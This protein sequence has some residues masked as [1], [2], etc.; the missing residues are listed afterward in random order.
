V[1]SRSITG[2]V[3][4]VVIGFLFLLNNLGRNIP[5]WSLAWDYWPVL[6]IVI[7]VIGLVEALYHA[8]RGVPN[9][10][11]MAGVGIFWIVMLVAFFSW[12][13][14][15]GNIHFG[16][17]S[18]GGINILGTDYEYD[19]NATGAS[20][21]V[22][23]V[24]LDNLHGNLSLKGQEAG[25]DVKVSGKKSVRAFSR[26]DAEQADRE[27]PIRIERQGDLLIIHADEPKSSH[28]LSVS[29]D[30]DITIPKGIDVE[31]RGRAGDLTIDDI[32]GDVDIT[33][34][35]GDIRLS[36]IAKDVKV[37][38]TRGGLIRAVD[39]KGKVDLEGPRGGD[40][41]LENV[42]GA[43]TINGEYS[44]TLE[45]HG[46]AKPL[47]FQSQK[48][49]FRLEA[50]PG[51]ITL[52]LGD[53][54]MSNVTG[55]VRFQT[56]SRD[57]EATDVTVGLEIAVQRGDV[58]ITQTKIPLPKLDIHSHNGD[59]TLA[60]PE[61]AGFELDGTTKHGDVSNDFGDPLKS[62]QDG[63]AA[64]IRGKQGTG[65]QI[66]IGTDRGTVTVKKS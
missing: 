37:E 24:V 58:E 11:R 22:S 43:V 44:G 63:R 62:E 26:N 36:N 56:S 50:V 9:P 49:D 40:I 46:L 2:P 32:G 1:R 21:G 48:T 7:G 65:P 34:G 12:A 61:K 28:M 6:L 35:H 3:I 66:T 39:I 23:R 15:H 31:A 38:A 14:N 5:F 18:N 33:G 29:A 60:V 4:L 45:F 8:S 52:D 64:S 27:S 47:H 10:P 13:G 53:L 54:K 42:Q 57:I 17:F 51:N 41:Q 19:V 30:L 16:P 55:P 25:G 59:I 20:Q